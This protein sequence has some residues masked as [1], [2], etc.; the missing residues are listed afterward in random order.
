MA[1]KLLHK[2]SAVEEKT[3]AP[4]N[5][6]YGELAINYND[7]N[8]YIKKSDDS[9]AEM[10]RLDVR[11]NET[12]ITNMIYTDGDITQI[13][14]STGNKIVLNYNVNEDVQSIDYY[15]TD[16]ITHLYTQTLIYNVDLD[17][18]GTTWSNA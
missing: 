3:P 5:L 18:T 15:A 8:I 17:L 11:L 16:S 1:N 7:G 12:D 2:K 10:K 14:Y 4:V 6:D 9:I 13:E